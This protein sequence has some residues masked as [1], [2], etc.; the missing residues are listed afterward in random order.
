MGV[1]FMF[2]GI[3]RDGPFLSARL[4]LL[5]FISNIPKIILSKLVYCYSW[6]VLLFVVV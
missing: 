5:P 2:L 1:W 3:K 4:F 6:V